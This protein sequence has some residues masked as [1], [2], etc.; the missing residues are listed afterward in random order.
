MYLYLLLNFW[1]LLQSL[2]KPAF[3]HSKE[4]FK[5]TLQIIILKVL[6]ENK[7][8]YGYEITHTVREI[9]KEKIQITEGA[10]YPIL[11]KLLAEGVLKTEE[12]ANGKR[13]RIYYSITKKGQS[14]VKEKIKEMHEF[15][16]TLEV[17]FNKYNY[18]GI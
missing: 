11:H 1:L 6:A 18:A 10:L 14:F 7:R 17:I 3:M 9:T 12:E 5:G 16:D 13:I 15:M 4:L 8:M 2:P